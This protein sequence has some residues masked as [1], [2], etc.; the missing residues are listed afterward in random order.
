MFLSGIFHQ[1][2]W[3]GVVIALVLT[4]ITIVCVTLFL[5]RSQTHKAVDFD[6]RVNHFFR[7][8]L[9]LTTGQV[10]KQ[11]VAIHRKHHAKCETAED[12][13]SPQIYGIKEVLFNGLGL[14]R[15]EAKNQETIKRYGHGCPDDWLERN[16][17]GTRTKL[18]LI[19]MAVI[20]IACF[21]IIPGLLIY[22][23]QLVWIPFW[24]AGVV[25]GVGHYWGY[26]NYEV[27]DTSTNVCPIGII[28]GG[29]E[30]HNNHHA[31]G[32]AA[33]FSTKWYE[34]DLGWGYIRGLEMLGLA[35]VKKV[36]PE[37]NL[38]K[39]K[40]NC[41]LDTLQAVINHRYEVLTNFGGIL[42]QAYSAELQKSGQSNDAELV[43][44]KNLINQNPKNLNETQQ[45]NLNAVIEKSTALSTLY[46]MRE[47]LSTI[48]ERSAESTEQLITKLEDWC[49]RAE[50]SGIAALADFSRRLRSYA[51]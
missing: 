19:I 31:Y 16:V 9:W 25:N 10:T 8:W 42:K 6:N 45:A 49:K 22:A 28:I 24:A 47:E 11:W 13:H 35:K 26:R 50:A 17:Y 39:S 48:W 20:D 40:T 5:H 37:V 27:P 18:G 36:I 1:T 3:E 41:D 15:K 33:K 34:F 21:G 12:P 14:Y 51:V 2:F 29:E 23:T 7:F 30:L 43:G 46:A 38:D 4:H 44:M 32:T